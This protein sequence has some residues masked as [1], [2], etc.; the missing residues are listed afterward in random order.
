MAGAHLFRAGAAPSP[1]GSRPEV[2]DRS[3]FGLAFRPPGSRHF[4]PSA[5]PQDPAPDF[6]SNLSAGRRPRP[7]GLSS[8]RAALGE[9]D[10]RRDAANHRGVGTHEQH[11]GAA[12][13]QRTRAGAPATQLT[14][15]AVLG[16]RAVLGR[17]RR[18]NGR[19]D[20]PA[21]VR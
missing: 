8:H 4:S 5:P 12:G 21:P 2:D 18:F 17:A 1:G 14:Y 3:G 19:T 7:A 15:G 10:A 20:T 11:G 13:V 6:N 9:R 16:A